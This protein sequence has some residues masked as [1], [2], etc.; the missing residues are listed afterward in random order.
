V[1]EEAEAGPSL[2]LGLTGP[3]GPTWELVIRRVTESHI[4]YDKTRFQKELGAL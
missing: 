3:L 1:Q 2:V 4:P